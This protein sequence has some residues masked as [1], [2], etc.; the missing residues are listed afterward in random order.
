MS[1]QP[2][3]HK[4]NKSSLF[5][6][7]NYSCST[8]S[9]ALARRWRDG[10]TAALNIVESEGDERQGNMHRWAHPRKK[11][12]SH[13]S[14]TKG[15]HKEVLLGADLGHCCRALSQEGPRPTSSPCARP[16]VAGT[17][18]RSV[19]DLSSGRKA[20]ILITPPLSHVTAVSQFDF[21]AG[22]PPAHTLLLLQLSSSR[23]ASLHCGLAFELPTK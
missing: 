6:R 14:A 17:Q 9:T 11:G 19:P 15:R 8:C 4:S 5:T 23:T 1:T 2:K 21:T 3:N 13:E 7:F 18:P 20:V 12:R 16:G 10:R 22:L